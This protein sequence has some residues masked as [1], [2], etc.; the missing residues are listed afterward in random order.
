MAAYKKW[1]LDFDNSDSALVDR[2][3]V[4][5]PPGFESSSGREVVSVGKPVLAISR[6]LCHFKW[7]Y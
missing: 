6:P 7:H 3:H 4:L 5:D 1:K 2:K